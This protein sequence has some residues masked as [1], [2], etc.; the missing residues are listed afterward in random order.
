M[1]EPEM[2]YA[3]KPVYA[4]I[5]KIE[6]TNYKDYNGNC[7]TEE[8][9]VGIYEDEK[10]AEMMKKRCEK[11][12]AEDVKKLFCD[13]CEFEIR[14]INIS[15][16]EPQPSAELAQEYSERFDELR[17]NRMHMSFYKYGPAA[18]NYKKGYSKAIPSL[19][20]CLKKYNETANTEYLVDAANYAM[21]EFMYPQHEKAHFRATSSDESAGIVGF[22]INEM[23]RFE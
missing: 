5:K 7:P 3:G 13:P 15:T 10:I 17:K 18:V 9:L 23:K 21:L 2:L 14:K 4:L 12:D 8:I 20:N 6:L 11:K 19:E 22:P 1:K 16:S